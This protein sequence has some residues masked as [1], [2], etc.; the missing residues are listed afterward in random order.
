MLRILV[1]DIALFLSLFPPFFFLTSTELF[2]ILF[3]IFSF[4][5]FFF[6]PSTLTRGKGWGWGC[7]Y[8]PPQDILIVQP[9][10]HNIPPHHIWKVFVLFVVVEVQVGAVNVCE[11]TLSHSFNQEIISVSQFTESQVSTSI[12]FLVQF[13]SIV[14]KLFHSLSFI[15]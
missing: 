14:T 9:H 7:S 2:F 3:L 8:P 10:H 1:K 11:I 15:A 12:S 5:T 6:L 13:S 4:S